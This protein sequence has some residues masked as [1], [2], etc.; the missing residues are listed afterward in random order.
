[1]KRVLSTIL[2]LFI[3]SNFAVSADAIESHPYTEIAG[4]QTELADI[5]VEDELIIEDLPRQSTR[6]ATR[7]QTYRRKDTVIAIIAL[8]AEFSYTGSS[9]SVSSKR[10]TQSTTYD[11]WNY[12]QY[13]LSGIGGTVTL[14]GNLTK[15]AQPKVPVNL[16]ITCDVHGNIT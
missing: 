6:K 3:I 13:S 1:M 8:T 11:G 7:K 4:I 9:V 14:K 10:V 12:N 5:S 16:T 2:I 15:F